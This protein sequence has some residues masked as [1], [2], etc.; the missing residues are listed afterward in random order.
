MR[1][2]EFNSNHS[3]F[4]RVCN[5]SLFATASEIKPKG[6]NREDEKPFVEKFAKL[7]LWP[8]ENIPGKVWGVLNN[9]RWINLALTIT[10]MVAVSRFFYPQQTLSALNYVIKLIPVPS[11]E[12]MELGAYIFTMTN[13]FGFFLRAASRLNNDQLMKQFEKQNL[14]SSSKTRRVSPE[15]DGEIYKDSTISPNAT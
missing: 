5:C 14:S 2:L 15:Q 9:P 11:R 12:T 6:K 7:I 13:I 10:S 8:L 1:S 4:K 3:Y